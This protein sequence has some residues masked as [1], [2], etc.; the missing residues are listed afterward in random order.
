[1]RAKSCI[2]ERRINPQ[3]IAELPWMIWRF[4]SHL[5]SARPRHSINLIKRSLPIQSGYCRRRAVYT[6]NQRSSDPTYSP[7]AVDPLFL[8][9]PAVLCLLMID[10]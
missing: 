8:I 6:G 9:L 2:I 1:M 7:G 3:Y 10:N 4:L 5:T